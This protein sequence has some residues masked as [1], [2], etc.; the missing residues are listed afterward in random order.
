MSWT[1]PG[2]N[3]D[4]AI[5]AAA[6]RPATASVTVT[7]SAGSSD[8]TEGGATDTYDV[9]LD[10]APSGTVTITISPDSQV[11][12]SPAALTF[13]TSTW[14]TT[15]TVTVTAVDDAVVEPAHTGTITH[16][17]A[18]GGYDGVS[19][20]N[21]VANVTDNDASVTLSE[22]AG[23]TDVAEGGATDTYDVVLDAAPFSTVTITMSA[24]AQVTTS[25]STLTFTTSD[26]SAAQT[27]TVTAVD[28]IVAEGAHTGTITH[29][30]AGGGYDGVSI[31]NVVA[32]VTDNDAPPPGVT[33]TES[34]GSTDVTEGGASD[35]YDMVLD[36]PPSGTVTITI[37][38]DSQVN[39]SPPTLTFTTSDWNT[40]QTVTV[41][42]VDDAVVEGA[43]TGTITHSAAG[44]GY[45]GVSISNVVANVTDDDASVTLT[46][47]AGSTDVA[48][49]GATDTY[50]VVL[51]AAP[52][53]T[54]TIT[55]SAD[56]E[57]TTSPATLTFT[58]GDWS[59]AQTV[60]VTA[61]DDAVV[62]G[63][64]TGTITHS[65]SGGG[66]DSVSV[67]N[68]V[69][70]VTD[71]DAASVTVTESGG[72]TDVTEGGATDTY[73]VVLDLEPSGTVTIGV[74]PDAQVSVSAAT[75]TFTTGNWSA[76]Q[77]VTVTAVD[78]A[79][80]EGPHTGTITHSASGGSYDGVSI[81]NVVANITDDE[82]PPP[83]VLEQLQYRWYENVDAIQPTTPLAA[84]NSFVAGSVQGAVYHLRINI[85]VTGANLA[86]GETFN[87]NPPKEGVGLAS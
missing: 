79:V 3:R 16:S 75:L 18:G 60:T 82:P 26:W 74:S 6:L 81:P 36:A 40:A 7:E 63:A 11:T 46:E 86:S 77:T 48:E 19:I 70:N 24:D 47:S 1:T 27:V 2:Q 69:A 28:D 29:S 15:Q 33:V 9:V 23:S 67:P 13:T 39:A 38:P 10:A 25:P 73:D 22:S 57:V 78:D 41:T 35:I 59:A 53:G 51:D 85:N 76:T 37:S 71:N 44:G 65:P 84:E 62:E 43:H 58:T 20:S 68:V 42:A 17:A 52:F 8:V 72:S 66:Y 21:V 80:F 87:P 30:A 45:D 14:S 61:V 54:V 49:G 31:P 32:N 64:H 55:M 83:Q 56:V 5:S 50:D 34:A 4:W 12:T